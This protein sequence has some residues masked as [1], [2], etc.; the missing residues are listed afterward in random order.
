MNKDKHVV[1]SRID[2]VCLIMIAFAWCFYI[3]GIYERFSIG[4][5]TA[6]PCL[7]VMIIV[8]VIALSLYV[9]KSDRRDIG[10]FVSVKPCAHSINLAPRF[11]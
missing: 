9:C 1:K 11:W 10:L 7:V 5:V 6:Y 4:N 2:I 3:K 8:G